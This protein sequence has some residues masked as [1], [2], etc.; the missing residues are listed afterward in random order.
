[1]KDIYTVLNSDDSVLD[2]VYSDQ[3]CKYTDR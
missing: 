2:C 3:N 1:M